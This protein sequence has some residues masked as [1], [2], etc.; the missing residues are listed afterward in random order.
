MTAVRRIAATVVECPTFT[1]RFRRDA[2]NVPAI[3]GA[4]IQADSRLPEDDRTARRHF[5]KQGRQQHDGPQ[6]CDQ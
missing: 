3:P 5:D 2:C 6:Q 1:R 4:Q